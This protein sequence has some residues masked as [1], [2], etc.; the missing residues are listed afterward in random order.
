MG[1]TSYGFGGFD[2]KARPDFTAQRDS[3]GAW[4]ARN[5]FTMLREVCETYAREL[6]VKGA[7][8]TDLYPELNSY[9]SFLT[10][11]SVEVGNEP[12]AITIARC[13]WAGWSETEYDEDEDVVYSLSGTRV[14]RPIQEHPLFRKEVIDNDDLR[15]IYKAILM[16]AIKGEFKINE[17]REKDPDVLYVISTTDASI[18][19]PIEN[20]TTIKWLEIILEQGIK[21][22]QAPTL[23]WT[24]ETSSAT[25]WRDQDLNKLGLIEYDGNNRPPGSPPMPQ[26]GTFNWLKISMN[27]TQEGTVVQQSQTWELSP[28][29]GFRPALLYDYD[30]SELEGEE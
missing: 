9:W 20:P 13:T 14:E 12:G 4:S 8:I 11:E 24:E 16:G 19:Y 21:T 28:P 29:G 23:Q 5:S 3:K 26:Y 6:F 22:Y 27:Q 30:L 17:G 15:G 18:E 2:Y 7:L 10:L 25:G 1:A